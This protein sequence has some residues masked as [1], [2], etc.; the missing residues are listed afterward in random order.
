M[1]RYSVRAYSEDGFKPHPEMG[2]CVWDKETD[3][4]AE[5]NGMRYVN[6]RQEEAHEEA[7]GLNNPE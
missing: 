5:A 3:A 7:E 6:L 1:A 4:P 2:W